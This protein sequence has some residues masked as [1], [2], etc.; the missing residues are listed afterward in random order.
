MKPVTLFSWGYWGWGNATAELRRMFDAVETARG[1]APPLFV[2]IR[3]SRS[4]RAKGFQG[5]AFARRVGPARYRWL[6]SLGNKA[7][8]TGS[9]TAM[10]INDPKGV[11]ELL[12]IATEAA[13]E[14]RRVVFFCACECP[15]CEGKTNC[16]RDLVGTLV[17]KAARERS[18][19]IQVVEWP[20]GEPSALE[21]AL[22]A[23]TVKAIFRGRFY[24]PYG[25]QLSLADAGGIAFGSRLTVRSSAGD[26]L[27]LVGPAR[28]QLSEWVLPLSHWWKLPVPDPEDDAEPGAESER[29]R[30]QRGYNPRSST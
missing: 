1:F 14:K 2:D 28:C 22:P 23:E 6:R 25:K 13:V 24:L 16:H 12:D 5:G 15:R 10:A 18:A 26:F 29:L 8:A 7:I 11:E 4:V 19:N 17:L 27:A 9:K 30:A 20:G 3:Y 21:V